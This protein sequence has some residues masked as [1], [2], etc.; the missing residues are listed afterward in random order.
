MEK[1]AIVEHAKIAEYVRTATA[2][3]FSTMLGLDVTPKPER[4]DQTRPVI[5][6]GVMALVGLA[7]SWTGAGVITCS[8]AFA[9]QICNHLLMAE[10]TSVNEDVLDAMGEVANMIIG[11]F[12]TLVEDHLGPL[13][14]SI[15]TVV[16]GRN[17]SARSIGNNEWVV[18]PFECVGNVIEIRISLAPSNAPLA[19]RA[20]A[21]RTAAQL[22]S[23]GRSLPRPS[24]GSRREPVRPNGSYRYLVIATSKHQTRDG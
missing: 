17:F 14:L 3:V 2:E 8:A 24:T 7:G 4:L 21:I 13:G 11:N 18:L 19:P 10:E 16:Y 15:P 20:G 12:K 23:V 6:E 1:T 22:A 5:S 9:I